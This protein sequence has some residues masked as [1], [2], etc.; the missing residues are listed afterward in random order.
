MT[1]RKLLCKDCRAHAT[2]DEILKAPNPFEPI[3][4]LWGCPNCKSVDCFEVACDEDG[5]WE[6][7]T[8]GTPTPDG[9]RNTCSKHRP[10]PLPDVLRSDENT[11]HKT[12][13]EG[14]QDV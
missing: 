4:D 12:W 11:A 6:S 14:R 3:V 9:Y 2:E 13:R 1:S 7:V 8:C 10:S 5:C